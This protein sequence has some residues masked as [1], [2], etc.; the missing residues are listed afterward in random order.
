MNHIAI[1]S[2]LTSGKLSSM[3]SGKCQ[4]NDVLSIVKAVNKNTIYENV[5]K[6]QVSGLVKNLEFKALG[7]KSTEDFKIITSQGNAPD[8]VNITITPSSFYPLHENFRL[9]PAPD[10]RS[11]LFNGLFSDEFERIKVRALYH[12]ETTD[13]PESVSMYA[14]K[15]LLFVNTCSHDHLPVF[16]KMFLRYPDYLH[17]PDTYIHYYLNFFLIRVRLFYEKL[18]EKFLDKPEKTEK[19]LFAE[20]FHINESALHGQ[21]DSTSD[22]KINDNTSH[23]NEPVNKSH[24]K[25]NNQP[26]LDLDGASP[27]A[28][29]FQLISE[30]YN[31][32]AETLYI[33]VRLIGSTR[34]NG[35]KQALADVIFQLTNEIKVD[36]KPILEVKPSVISALLAIVCFDKD[37]EPINKSTIQNSLQPNKPGKRP[38]SG[39]EEKI[40]VKQLLT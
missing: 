9:K 6:S 15:S 8:Q 10:K 25:N 22:Y 24:S 18:F 11:R 20:L 3:L 16:H 12:L 7:Y 2:E 27:L 26:Q 19:Q 1:F 35:G 21:D 17:H 30:E 13:D 36:D 39:S 28:R 34:W 33:L 37:G 29:A 32:P 5:L 14:V 38:K 23:V 31:I 4:Y 40:N